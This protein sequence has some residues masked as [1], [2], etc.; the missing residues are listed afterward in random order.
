MSA[1]TKRSNGRS[2]C[3]AQA[4]R[5]RGT[6]LALVALLCAMPLV[7]GAQT[8]VT[9][10]KNKYTPEQDVELGL[11]AAEEARREFPVIDDPQV[12]RA[13]DRIGQRLVAAAPAELNHSAFQYSFTPLNLKEINAF[14][15]PGGPMFVNRGM[16]EAA[17]QEGEVAG[18]MAHELSHVL[19]RHGTAN[20]TKAQGFQFG[21][22]AGAIAGAVVGGGWGE[23]ISQGSQFGLGT[24]LLKYSRDYEKQA[25]L[26]GAQIMARAGYD[27]RDLARMFETIQRESKGSGGPQWMSSHPN[28]G[29]RTQYIT[30]EASALQIAQRQ[31][32]PR[33]FDSFKQAFASLP[34]PRSM[35]EP[36]RNAGNAPTAHTGR[37]GQPVP[38]P[39]AQ[40]R[41]AQGGRLFQVSVPS[42]WQ[43]ISSNNSVKFVPQNAYGQVE[44]GQTV[45][46]HGIELGVS[47]APSR[48]LR[49]ST[50]AFIDALTRANPGLRIAGDPQTLNLS[51]RTAIGTPLVGQ[52]PLG[53]RERIGVYTTFLSDGN[54]F[55]YL[56]VVPEDEAR[57]YASAF[58]RVG[59]S[60]RLNDSR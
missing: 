17:S 55:Y 8:K 60:I 15:L 42:N 7:L 22:L 3:S 34:A 9:P 52:S 26:L 44:G 37:I 30:K 35:S 46:T 53:T 51:R 6:G 4:F 5:K 48:D 21:A 18:V 14:A 33:Q 43:A 23:L 38:P 2:K 13:L 11:K 56:T 58:E 1:A 45:F 36:S 25:D 57:S 16:V 49:Q 24:W 31:D 10:P 47:R 50:D 40:F 19:L 39:A 32:D 29:N 28:P 59:Q 54:L 12:D 41:T 27:P 20:A